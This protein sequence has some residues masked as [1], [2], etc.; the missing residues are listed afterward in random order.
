MLLD[1]KE[2]QTKRISVFFV[3]PKLAADVI[4]LSLVVKRTASVN[5]LVPR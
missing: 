5:V 1:R 2:P 4:Y 3:L